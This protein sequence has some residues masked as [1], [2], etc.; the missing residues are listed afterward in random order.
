MRQTE[1]QVEANS[2][3]PLLVVFGAATPLVLAALHVV[4]VLTVEHRLFDMREEN[5]L[6][7]WASSSLFLAAAAVALVVSKEAR[8][9]A[10][11]YGWL[12]LS[13]LALAM[14][15]DETAGVHEIAGNNLGAEATLSMTQP[16]AAAVVVVGLV[17][18]AAHSTRRVRALLLI[19]CLALVS[20]QAAASVGGLMTSGT[21]KHG[22]EVLEE[23]TETWLAVSLLAASVVAS[24]RHLLAPRRATASARAWWNESPANVSAPKKLRVR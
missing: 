9:R 1:S 8:T 20:S 21:T 18:L 24:G 22:L 7:T 5:N 17:V 23:C 19:G 12:G 14:S 3:L 13:L 15:L 4:D 11:R 10:R 6:P 2:P 16:A